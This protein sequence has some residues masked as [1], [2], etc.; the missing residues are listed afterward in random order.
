MGET[1]TRT[2]VRTV[3]LLRQRGQC[4]LHILRRRFFALN[5]EVV[6]GS[7][8]AVAVAIAITIHLGIGGVVV[9]VLLVVE[10]M[11]PGI[12]GLRAALLL[13]THTTSRKSGADGRGED[14]LVVRH[15]IH[16]IIIQV[17]GTVILGIIITR[18]PKSVGRESTVTQQVIPSLAPEPARPV[19]VSETSPG[20][21][22]V[23]TG[24]GRR[25]AHRQQIAGGADG[26]SF[27]GVALQVGGGVAEG[28]ARRVVG[29]DWRVGR[30]PRGMFEVG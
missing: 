22:A 19:P 24:G 26:G 21:R 6:R 27:V 20:W 28:E 23:S 29:W 14:I 16:I 25:G 7:D 17:L 18:L 10:R 5:P 12:L 30:G 9:G 4:R 3:V 8:M 13:G 2:V 11:M 15:R 1:G